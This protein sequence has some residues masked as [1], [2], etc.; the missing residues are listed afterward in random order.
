[1]RPIHDGGCPQCDDNLIS[2]MPY[3]SKDLKEVRVEIE[4]PNCGLRIKAKGDVTFIEERY[5]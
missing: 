4:C 2:Y 1:M 3:F 5:S